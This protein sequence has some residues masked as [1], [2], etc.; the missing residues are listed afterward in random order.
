[1]SLALW[2]QEEMSCFV[3]TVSPPTIE[4]LQGTGCPHQKWVIIRKYTIFQLVPKSSLQ[5]QQL[6]VCLMS[7]L[8]ELGC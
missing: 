2:K 7:L 5:A 6:L 4:I 8:F 1:M 3:Q